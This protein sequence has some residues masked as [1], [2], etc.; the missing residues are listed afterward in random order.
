MTAGDDQRAVLSSLMAANNELA[1]LHREVARQ[2]AEL[3]DIDRRKDELLA[4]VAHDLR[5]PLASIVGFSE[6]LR[7]RQDTTSDPTDVQL[8][9]RIEAQAQRMLAL[10]DEL[11]DSSNLGEVGVQL[12]L[13]EID[14][15]EL[16]TDGL[17]VHTLAAERKQVRLEPLLPSDPVVAVADG[18]RLARV[19][20]NLL[21][22]AVKFTPPGLD[23]RVAVTCR[24]DG[25][26]RTIEV[27]DEG[28]G[29]PDELRTTLFD[30][31]AR[32]HATGTD[33][34]P[35]RGL[36]LAITRALVEAHAGRITIDNHE[37]GG[38]RCLIEL[39]AHGPGGA[40]VRPSRA[41]SPNPG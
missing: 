24:A 30:P 28:I 4:T 31:F 26:L 17:T 12:V 14:L 41:G 38:V 9:A 20:D 35:T 29:L 3:R 16:V 18:R 40:P 23:R 27:V 2:A 21:T 25:D 10:V 33:G 32:G 22:N 7:R 19:L 11:L 5:T 1:N 39:P 37:R 34:E 8:V 15:R 13:E 36:G 6:L